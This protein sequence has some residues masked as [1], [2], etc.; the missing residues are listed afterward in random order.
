MSSVTYRI[1]THHRNTLRIVQLQ[2]SSNR[3]RDVKRLAA[4]QTLASLLVNNT[5]TDVRSFIQSDPDVNKDKEITN[6]LEVTFYFPICYKSLT[7]QNLLNCFVLT[8]EIVMLV[9]LL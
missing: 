7:R 1:E 4:L 8:T 9:M 6:A 3:G 2:P 5:V